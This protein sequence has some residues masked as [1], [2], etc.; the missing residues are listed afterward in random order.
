MTLLPMWMDGLTPEMVR[1]AEEELG[2]FEDVRIQ[3]LKGFRRLINGEAEFRPRMDDA[4]LLRFLRARKFDPEKAFN[5]LKNYYT[6]KVRYSKL[7]TDFKP[8][9]VKK[10]LQMNIMMPLPKRLTDGS[11]VGLLRVGYFD[12]DVATPD[13][14]FAAGLV[15]VELGLELESIQVCGGSVIFDME[16]FSLRL[17]RHFGSP[18]FLFRMVRVVQDCLPCRVRGFH[19]VNEPFFFSVVFNIIKQFLTEKIKSRIHFHGSNLKSLHKHIPPEILPEELGG[20]LGPMDS[21]EFR[22]QV[23]NREADFERMNKYGFQE[24]RA[25]FIR[26]KSS[27]ALG[28]FL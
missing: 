28:L 23:L 13:D 8:S 18:T 7:L 26:K 25:H 4:F 17:L 6:F 15:C 14:L 10:V 16:K 11:A 27:R 12:I 5:T 1:K 24:K 3:A 2:E 21:T 19:I 9:E 22:H 20:E